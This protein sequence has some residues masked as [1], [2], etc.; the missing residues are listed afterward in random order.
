MDMEETEPPIFHRLTDYK[1]PRSWRTWLLGRPLPTADAPHQTVGKAVGMA[2]FSGDALSS[3]AYAPQEMLVVLAVAGAAGFAYVFPLAILVTVLLAVVTMSYWQAILVYPDGG[4]AYIVARDNLGEI[5]AQVA[6]AALLVD[7]V[8]LAA[9]AIS[10]GVSQVISA[11][12]VLLPYRVAMCVGFILLIMLANLRGVRESGTAFA[13]PTY[14]FL[15]MTFL[16]LGVALA[17]YAAGTLGTVVD[18]PAMEWA[19]ALQPVTILLILRAFSNG[20]TALTGVECI[21]NGVTAFREPRSRNAAIT[22]VWMSMILAAMFLGISFL[23]WQVRALPSEA[24]TVISQL[25]RTAFAGRG[26]PYLATMAATTIILL[27]ATNTAFAGF[28]RLSAIMANDSFLPRQLAFRGSRLVYSYGIVALAVIA[29]LLVVIFDARVTALVPLWAVGV[30]LS[31]TL[32]QAGMARRWWKA[33]H[34]KPGGEVRERGSTLRYQAGWLPKMLLN[35][36]GALCTAA[37]TLVFAVTR[38][39]DG[40]WVV[41]ILLPALVAAFFAIQRHYQGLTRE[42]SLEHYNAPSCVVRHRVILPVSG[43]HRGTLAALSYARML[44]D[45]VTAVHVSMD[46]TEAVQLRRKWELWGEGVRLVILD[47]PYRLLI[48]PLLQYVEQVAAQRQHNETITIVVPQFVPRHWWH[49][50]LHANAATVLR[51]ALLFKRGI[52]V[53]DVPYQVE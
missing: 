8:L 37:V 2:I 1:P 21:S 33:G 3:V 51:F 50:L 5:A 25:A 44:S 12:P 52:V 7:Y 38:F 13:I 36:L 42:L 9:V 20:T 27:L 23:L 49:N 6:G 46:E 41:V 26:V 10:S 47:S 39:R 40:T 15:L 22:T 34:L 4:G 18:P 30:F 19:G 11:F 28:P 29:A 45:D 35:G 14:F 32:L 48:E 53:T 31:F 17:R 43:V 24:E 16:T